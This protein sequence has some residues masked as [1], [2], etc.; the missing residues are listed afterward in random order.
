MTDINVKTVTDKARKDAAVV[1]KVIYANEIPS[2]S[3]IHSIINKS[4]GVTEIPDDVMVFKLYYGRPAQYLDKISF[5]IPPDTIREDK[6]ANYSSHEIVGRFEPIRV[7]AGSSPTTIT[8]NVSYIWLSQ[9]NASSWNE[10][11][12][13]IT[14]LRALT[15]PAI[16]DVQSPGYYYLENKNLNVGALKQ[17]GML[18]PP[19]LVKF[20]FGDLYNNLDC[21]VKSVNLTFNSPWNDNIKV[22]I[23]PQNQ[24]A[25]QNSIINFISRAF[26][27]PTPNISMSPTA[28]DVTN[29][30]KIFPLKTEVAITLETAYPIGDWTSYQKYIQD[31]FLQTNDS[32]TIRQ[33]IATS[34]QQEDKVQAAKRVSQEVK[35]TQS[36]VQK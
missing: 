34:S 36:P 7:Y 8:F 17:V 1:G 3:F 4:Q 32:S 21:I 19:P 12:I 10:L 33:G 16:G 23:P 31:T 27:F 6:S 18:V 5:Q 11:K 24:A 26:N 30:N 13:N 14:K 2:N 35:P 25:N 28:Y 15:Y 9:D 20:T 22:A 29:A